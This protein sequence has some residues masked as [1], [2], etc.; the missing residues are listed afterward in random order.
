MIKHLEKASDFD[1]ITKGDKNVLVDFFATWCGPCRMTGRVIEEIEGEY[2]T[3]TFL[4][5]D[6]DQFPEIAQ[7]FMVTSIPSFIAYKDGQN[8]SLK[9]GGQSEFMHVGGMDEQTLRDYL[10]ETFAL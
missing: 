10:A 9:I 3:V 6:V 1:V 5:I 2:P 7:N 4:K 8:V